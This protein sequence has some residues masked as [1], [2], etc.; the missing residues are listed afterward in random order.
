MAKPFEVKLLW[1][2]TFVMIIARAMLQT[3]SCGRVPGPWPNST[4]SKTIKSDFHV[5]KI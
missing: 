2:Y 1:S 3:H 4:Y 5:M